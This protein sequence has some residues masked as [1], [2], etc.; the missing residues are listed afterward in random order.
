MS[1][2]NDEYVCMFFVG[3]EHLHIYGG[4]AMYNDLSSPSSFIQTQYQKD[5]FY[6]NQRA[7]YC[8]QIAASSLDSPI[9]SQM[10]MEMKVRSTI[11][12][13]LRFQRDA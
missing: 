11:S 13:L 12:Q 8:Y 3:L 6:S 2:A 7:Q 4:S 5:Y 9:I 1:I 10:E